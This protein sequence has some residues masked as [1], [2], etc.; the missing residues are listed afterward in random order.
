[1]IQSITNSIINESKVFIIAEAGVNHNG[2]VNIAKKMIDAAVGAKADAVK[3]QSYVTDELIIP[4]ARMAPYQKHNTKNITQNEMLKKLELSEDDQLLLQNYAAERKIEFISSPFDI[5]SLDLLVKMGVR[6]IKLP[7][8][9][10]TNIPLLKKVSSLDKEVI[11]STGMSSMNEIQ[12]ALDILLSDKLTRKNIR[13]LHCNSEYPTPLEDVNLRAMLSI[14]EMLNI[15]VGYS[16]HTLGIAVSVAAV[17]M[18][19]SI[20]EKHFTLDKTFDGPDHSASL[21]INELELMVKKIREMEIILGS[22]EKHITKS[23]EGNKIAV[24][25]S[26]V[27][28]KSIK[29]GDIL[30]EDLLTVKRPLDGVCAS[31]WDNY[32]GIKASRNYKKNELIDKL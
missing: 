14:K 15:R 8:G 23:E 22:S 29:K 1:M 11:L 6:I 7:S 4:Q 10:I 24:R 27:A 2:D 12:S 18:G 32:I 20:I 25:K 30:T 5:P 17:A 9:E 26:I 19:A 31:N 3:I 16:D 28:K 13:I 21:S